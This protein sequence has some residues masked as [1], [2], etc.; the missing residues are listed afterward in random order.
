[1]IEPRTKLT[2]HYPTQANVRL[3]C[4]MR[5]RNI[6]VSSVRDLVADPLT[7]AE[8][9]ARPYVRRSRWLAR[10]FDHDLNEWRNFYLGCTAE[11]AAPS[12]MRAGIF[13]SESGKLLRLV[14]RQF[15]PT[16]SDRRLLRRMLTVW[17]KDIGEGERLGV[18]ATDM[19]LIT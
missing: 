7:A 9:C 8:F 13:D 15:E 12:V 14:S 3:D 10:A 4:P 11:F 17:E 6:T 1:M 16:V 2:I 18:F 5:P 19:R